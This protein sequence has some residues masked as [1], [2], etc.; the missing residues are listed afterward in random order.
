M[1]AGEELMIGIISGTVSGIIVGVFLLWI[2]KIKWNKVFFKRRIIK[3]LSKY[4]EIKGDKNKEE[5]FTRKL[6]LRLDD[7]YIKLLRIGFR[8]KHYGG[9][10]R[11]QD[12]SEPRDLGD[13]IKDINYGIHLTRYYPNPLVYQFLIRRLD[14]GN[15]K[16]PDEVYFSMKYPSAQK[17]NNELTVLKD[18]IEY[19]KKKK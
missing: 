5:K 6:G 11:F 7:N 1:A 14:N 2:G 16:K 4:E 8:I 17:E 18:F 3:L 9:S 12:L 10:K 13:T 15:T 19:F